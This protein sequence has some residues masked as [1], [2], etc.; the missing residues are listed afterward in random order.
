MAEMCSIN[1]EREVQRNPKERKKGTG[2]RERALVGRDFLLSKGPYPQRSLNADENRS[3]MT[4]G[5]IG[6]N[7]HWKEREREEEEDNAHEHR[8]KCSFLRGH[9]GNVTDHVDYTES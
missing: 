1:D 8:C 5:A 6:S 3:Y 7:G 4:L 2:E 9:T